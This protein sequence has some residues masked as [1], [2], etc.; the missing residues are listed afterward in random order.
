MG[1]TYRGCVYSLYAQSPAS[2][3][4][5]MTAAASAAPNNEALGKAKANLILTLR[6]LNVMCD[7]LDKERLEWWNSPAK[8]K[9]RREWTDNFEQQKLADLN[10]INNQ[11]GEMIKQIQTTVGQ[12]ARWTLDVKEGLED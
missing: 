6:S 5:P 8:K 10:R 11:A 9:L 4:D 12:Y 1:I 7:I 3:D 2:K